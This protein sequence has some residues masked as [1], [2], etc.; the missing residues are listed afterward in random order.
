VGRNFKTLLGIKESGEDEDR[1]K[2]CVR[3][4]KPYTK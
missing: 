2:K 1:N 4:M 3:K